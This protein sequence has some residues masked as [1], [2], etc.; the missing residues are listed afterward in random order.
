MNSNLQF[1]PIR[2]PQQAQIDKIRAQYG[3]TSSSHSFCGLYLWQKVMGLEIALENDWFVVRCNSRREN[4]YFMPCGNQ[5]KTIEF[6]KDNIDFPQFSLCYL[7]K[8]DVQFCISNFS[9][10]M[11][12]RF[13]R[14]ASEYI[15]DVSEQCAMKGQLF[16]KTRK[17]I[18]HLLDNNMVE[19]RPLCKDTIEDAKKIVLEWAN[20]KSV[21][22]PLN[23]GKDRADVEIALQFLEQYSAVS[24]QGI[25]VY[26]NGVPSAVAAGT[27]ISSDT[28]D[29]CIAKQTVWTPGV[30]LFVK[31][32]LMEQLGEQYLWLNSEEDLGISG[33]REHKLEMHPC[34]LE[35]MW[36]GYFD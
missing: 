36:E 6:L 3:H 34:R 18:H 16:A 8:Q 30:N 35:Y 15:Y 1:E 26:L 17:K 21:L 27:Q 2:L 24:A 22:C 10:Q 13:D 11:R 32:A 28:F 25:L 33:L 4:C 12:F 20:E 29:L 9:K 5:N 14:N 23:Y 7:R 19:V 31:H